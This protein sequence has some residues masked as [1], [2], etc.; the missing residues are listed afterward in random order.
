MEAMKNFVTV[1]TDKT[2]HFRIPILMECTELTK[3]R[4][5]NYIIN[6]EKRTFATCIS[7]SVELSEINM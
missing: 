6:K 4:V 7:R 2:K 3:E 5:T 1:I